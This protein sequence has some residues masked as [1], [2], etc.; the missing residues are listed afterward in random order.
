MTNLWRG[1]NPRWRRSAIQTDGGGLLTSS[2]TNHKD[3]RVQDVTKC[4]GKCIWTFTYTLTGNTVTQTVL[5]E[6][7]GSATTYRFNT[8]SFPSW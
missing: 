2:S 8:V 7:R 1:I 5:T 3:L 6:P 4:L